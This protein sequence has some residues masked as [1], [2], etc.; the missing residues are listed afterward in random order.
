[1]AHNAGKG[2]RPRPFSISQEEYT[3]RLGQIFGKSPEP[4]DDDDDS[5]CPACGGPL[6][7]QIHWHYSYC[8]DCGRSIKKEP[9]EP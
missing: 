9:M 1:M 4:S 2:S 3:D 6:Y 8:D 5:D 7:T